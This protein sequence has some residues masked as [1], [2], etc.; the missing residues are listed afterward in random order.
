[1]SRKKH[2]NGLESIA[3]NAPVRCGVLASSAR[4]H[5]LRERLG[6]GLAGWIWLQHLTDESSAPDVLLVDARSAPSP[7][8]LLD[9]VRRW[10][11]VRGLTVVVW[12]ETAAATEAMSYAR[13][14]AVDVLMEGEPSHILAARLREAAGQ[15]GTVEQR[16]RR[17]R[18]LRDDLLAQLGMLCG[19][20]SGVYRDLSGSMQ[21]LAL[22]SEISALIR[23][24]LDL[25][26]LLRTVLEYMLKRTGPTNA[27]IFL[28]ST[29]GDF[30]LGGYANYDCPKDSAEMMFDDLAAVVGP[31][32]ERESQPLLLTDQDEIHRWLGSSAHWVEG[33][34]VLVTPSLDGELR[35]VVMLFRDRRI[36]FNRD[37]Q[38]TVKTIA[39]LLAQQLGRIVRTQNRHLP[40]D[41]WVGP[42]E[43]TR[44]DDLAA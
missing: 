34:S 12:T 31:K 16:L 20:L 15:H 28:P 19:D 3:A 13:A 26:S 40:K 22:S 33:S 27:A 1:M 29:T 18:S 43:G 37:V 44:G 11:G 39:S 14:G 10:T 4:M 6:D 25:E 9:D 36:G 5:V 30:T 2:V 21:H 17:E 8:T 32:A 23:Q 41:K 7:D 38:R 42:G 35:A 24:E